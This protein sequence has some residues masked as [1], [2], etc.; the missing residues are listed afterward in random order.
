MGVCVRA[1]LNG[2]VRAWLRGRMDGCICEGS[3][4]CLFVFEDR[5]KD[6]ARGPS[7]CA[8][9][10]RISSRLEQ[11]AVLYARALVLECTDGR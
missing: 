6:G 1:S 11:R 8:L 2:R 7:R 4:G 5:R 3:R 9:N 10:L